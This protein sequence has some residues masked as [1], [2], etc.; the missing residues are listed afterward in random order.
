MYSQEAIEVL[1]NRIGW[2]ELSSGLPFVLTPENLSAQSGKKFNWYHSLILVDNIYAAV[3]DTEMSETDFN[4]YLSDVRKQAVLS[5]LTSLL[6][7]YVD[8]D[9][10]NDYSQIIITR[11]TLFDDAIGYSVAIKMI[12]LF[13]STT[14]KNFNERSAKMSYQALK[15]EL[16]GAKNDNGHFIAKGIIFKLEQSIKKAQKIIFPYKVIVNSP[17]VW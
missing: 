12:E 14:R 6:E 17:S 2:S 5:V 11:P 1:I 8:Y 3:P 16:E 4:A 7:T 13:L 15:V 10:E 9:P